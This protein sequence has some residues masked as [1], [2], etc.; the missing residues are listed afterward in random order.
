MKVKISEHWRQEIINHLTDTK[1]IMVKAY[2][3][4]QLCFLDWV[5][6]KKIKQSWKYIP[7]KI[8]NRESRRKQRAWLDRKGYAVRWLRVDEIKYIFSKRNKEVRLEELTK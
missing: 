5:T 4:K 2:T 7:V 6:N 3:M 1:D 8:E